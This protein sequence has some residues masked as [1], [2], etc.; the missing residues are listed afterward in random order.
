MKGFNF[1]NVY[2]DLGRYIHDS[3]SSDFGVPE[4]SIFLNAH[5]QLP[6]IA[7]RIRI[8]TEQNNSEV[9]AQIEAAV[10]SASLLMF[11]GFGFERQ[12]MELFPRATPA[13]NM[14][15]VMGTVYGLSES[16]INSVN[17]DLS[18]RF[19]KGHGLGTHGDHD[20]CRAAAR[21]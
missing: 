21:V 14:K 5:Y 16:D 3:G 8:F 20:L 10:N 18:N 9:V 4:G 1:I 19:R 2:G 6:P 15:T 11:L 7:E 13:S 12:N 17:A